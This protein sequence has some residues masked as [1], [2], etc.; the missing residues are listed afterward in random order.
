MLCVNYTAQVRKPSPRRRNN[1]P[2]FRKNRRSPLWYHRD[3]ETA[4][5]DRQR[6]GRC[7]A[8]AV[9]D[10]SEEEMYQA[11]LQADPAYD[12]R[13]FFGVTSTGIFCFPSCSCRKPRRENVRFFRSREQALA[14]GFRPCKRC[15][16]DLDGGQAGYEAA[17]AEKARTLVNQDL[18]GAGVGR[19][20]TALAL[21][22]D[23]LQRIFR[24]Q[25][26]LPLQAYIRQQRLRRAAELLR[27]TPLPILAVAEQ[28]GFESASGFYAAFREVFG[29]APG[30]Y[31]RRTT[32]SEVA[33]APGVPDPPGVPQAPCAPGQTPAPPGGGS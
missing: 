8:L 33:G 1:P 20:A 6:S 24:R 15:R 23:H 9:Q 21:S 12:H 3:K 10:L 28:V 31:R 5:P 19:L 11:I 14:H 26:G 27:E 17:L 18:A 30:R 25:A 7:L 22:P 29:V 16:P 32:A 2:R 4:P 13:F